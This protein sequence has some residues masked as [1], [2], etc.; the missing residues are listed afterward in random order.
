MA[1]LIDST[2]ARGF[3]V[4]TE[5]YPYTAGSTLLQSAIFDPGGRISWGSPT[6]ICNGRPRTSG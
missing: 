3:D 6:G 4:T 1:A 5:V 2:K